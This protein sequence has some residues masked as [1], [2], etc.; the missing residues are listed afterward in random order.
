MFA[1][2]NVRKKEDKRNNNNPNSSCLLRVYYV[3]NQLNHR[4]YSERRSDI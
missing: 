3:P 1:L 2:I 4:D